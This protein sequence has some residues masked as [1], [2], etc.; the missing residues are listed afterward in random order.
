[1]IKYYFKTLL[2]IT[3]LILLSL[4][5]GCQGE[6]KRANNS[7]TSPIIPV[8]TA[9]P[10]SYSGGGSNGTGNGSSII[11]GGWGAWTAWSICDF[12]CQKKR[13]RFCDNPTPQNGGQNCSGLSQELL[14]CTPTECQSGGSGSGNV[15]P[16]GFIKVKEVAAAEHFIPVSNQYGIITYCFS[17]QQTIDANKYCHVHNNITYCHQKTENDIAYFLKAKPSVNTTSTLTTE[18]AAIT[19]QSYVLPTNTCNFS[20]FNSI[21]PREMNKIKQLFSYQGHCPSQKVLCE[22]NHVKSFDANKFYIAIVI[23]DSASKSSGVIFLKRED[24]YKF[25]NLAGMFLENESKQVASY[26]M[27]VC[28]PEQHSSNIANKETKLTM[29]QADRGYLHE[30]NFNSDRIHAVRIGEFWNYTKDSVS[31]LLDPILNYTMPNL[32]ENCKNKT[33]SKYKW[34]LG[35]HPSNSKVICTTNA[36]QTSENVQTCSSNSVWVDWNNKQWCL[37][38]SQNEQYYVAKGVCTPCPYGGTYDGANCLLGYLPSNG[39]IIDKKAYY[40]KTKPAPTYCETGDILSTNS[41]QS[42]GMCQRMSIT[43]P[44]NADSFILNNISIYYKPVCKITN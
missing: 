32:D 31:M 8:P 1:M 6:S 37:A 17:H 29:V 21:P 15:C 9:T 41:G 39:K 26:I 3:P 13:W 16:S 23:A 11:N 38:L 22:Q 14:N 33:S 35:Y 36:S 40:N 24:T 2:M 42:L 25:P 10:T 20:S 34:R 44:L 30:F 7:N 28:L 43:I 12:N 27:Q 18:L 5:V 4:L 19:K